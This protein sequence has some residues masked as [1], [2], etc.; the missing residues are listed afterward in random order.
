MRVGI[1]HTYATRDGQEMS[2]DS[3]KADTAAYR[4][5]ASDR[6]VEIGAL[7]VQ[8]I[9][10]AAASVPDARDRHRAATSQASLM[11]FSCFGTFRPC[12]NVAGFVLTWA[13]DCWLLQPV[14]AH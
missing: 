3:Y 2:Y 8:A 14:N 6:C 11:N 13:V 10:V 1:F 4:P 7:R 9:A 12:T 5:N